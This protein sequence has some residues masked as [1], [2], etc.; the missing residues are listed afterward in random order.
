[1]KLKPSEKVLLREGKEEPQTGKKISPKY[2]PDK[3]LLSKI[4]EEL[5]KLNKKKAKYTI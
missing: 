2:I 5:L 1:M 3:G 4:N